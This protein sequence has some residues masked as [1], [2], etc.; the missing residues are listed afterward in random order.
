MPVLITPAITQKEKLPTFV[1]LAKT[2]SPHARD[3]TAQSPGGPLF[4][5]R[6]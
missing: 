6:E 3:S 1:A 4:P 5:I 2:K